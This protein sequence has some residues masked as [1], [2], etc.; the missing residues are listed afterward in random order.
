MS[1]V[2]SAVAEAGLPSPAG[3][4][5]CPPMPDR[6]LVAWESLDFADVLAAAHRYELHRRGM[7]LPG[8]AEWRY[9]ADREHADGDT[10]GIGLVE[11]SAEGSALPGA[12]APAG[13][14]LRASAVSG[15]IM[16]PPGPALAGWLTGA[17]RRHLDDA[18]LVTTITG[19]RKLTLGPGAGTGRRR[20]TRPAAGGC[21][22]GWARR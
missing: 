20:G 13:E 6:L 14:S 18:A 4:D 8:Q 21:R 19:W 12:P 10:A 3:T 1:E 7:E 15:H 11:R 5:G 2:R 17:R 22:C 9:A 16:I